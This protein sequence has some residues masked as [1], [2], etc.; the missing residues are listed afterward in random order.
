MKKLLSVVLVA[1]TLLSVIGC[2]KNKDSEI[3]MNSIYLL[4]FTKKAQA[5][6]CLGNSSAS[7]FQ[8]AMKIDAATVAEKDNK[9]VLGVRFYLGEGAT[10]GKAFMAYELGNNVAEKDFTFSA[11]GWQYV[12]FD[13]PVE[14]TAGK[15]IYVGYEA[16][17]SGYFLGVENSNTALMK[18]SYIYDDGSWATFK[19]LSL[20]KYGL[21]IQAIC[22]GGNYASER[23]HDL[24]AENI[25]IKDNVRA[26][27]VV[28]F[29]A[30]V[31]NAGIKT[32]GNVT[33]VC[34]YGS[35][36]VNKTA[37]NLR[38][39]EVQTL[40]YTINGIGLDMNQI[41]I[42]VEEDGVSDDYATDN[43]A[44]ANINVFATDAPER[45][46][47]LIEEFTSQSCPNCPDGIA[48]LRE[49][50][51]GMQHP[52]KAA[53]IAHHSGY[54]DDIFTMTGDKT[55]A[56]KLGV[57][58][59]PACIIDRMNVKYSSGAAELVWH[60]GYATSALLDELASIPANATINMNLSFDHSDSTLTV[61]VTGMSYPND[62]YITVVLCQNG[63]VASQS[64]GGNDFVHN[65]I[66]RAY[67]TDA[68]GDKLTLDGDKKYS[69]SYT[70]T[71]PASIKGETSKGKEI[72]TD[73]PNMY[74][75]AFVHGKTA[76]AGAV[77]NAT[78]ANVPLTPPS[79]I[80]K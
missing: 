15:D 3:D 49:A 59:A 67:L 9:K 28:K 20:T 65:E 61:D 18:N 68:V 26:G 16:K 27:D 64:S 17:G 77:Y 55:I 5:D 54:A 13:T 48:N 42:Q 29:T 6:D 52:E 39:G 50:I 7:T 80:R 71:I 56:S 58:F 21:C 72:E 51:E 46:C 11:A 69:A 24:V 32:T 79:V 63:Y 40:D 14:I 35:E 47:I 76:N 2:K 53:W 37:T 19:S 22:V 31:R 73:I 36:V 12:I 74:V 33:I 75:V 78:K 43:K 44:T 34:K 1:V 45:T 8:T 66:V 25:S 10:G 41:T 4:G 60:P 70:Y 23:Q 30:Q 57:N 38:N 62:C